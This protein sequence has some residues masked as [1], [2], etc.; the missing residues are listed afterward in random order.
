MRR[1][2]AGTGKLYYFGY[3]SNMNSRV[4]QGRRAMRPTKIERAVL[5]DYRLVFNQPGVPWLEPSFANIEP[6]AGEYIEGVLYEITEDEMHRL[7]LSEGG[8]AYDVVTSIV[9]G[10]V[11][12][13]VEA[14]TF[15]THAVADGLLPSHR[16]MRLLIDGARERGL[17]A[18]WVQKLEDAP[19]HYGPVSRRLSPF[20]MMLNRACI[21]LGLPHPFS[22]WKRYH[23]ARTRSTQR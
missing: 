18:E 17:S 7:D 10:E 5:K 1:Q 3:G 12:G 21:R 8:G 13:S 2:F 19:Y 20:I 4:F 15:M 16:Y 6:A 11:S 14:H 23:I 22:W 9:E